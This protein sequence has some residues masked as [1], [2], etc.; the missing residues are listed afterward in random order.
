MTSAYDDRE[1]MVALTPCGCIEACVRISLYS[2]EELGLKLV[3]WTIRGL[4]NFKAI[5]DAE[6]MR[7]RY[8]SDCRCAEVQG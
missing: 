4:G 7:L 6:Y 3:G 1:Y 2:R 5:T 8:K